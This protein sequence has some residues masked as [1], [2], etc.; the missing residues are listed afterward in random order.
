MTKLMRASDSLLEPPQD[1]AHLKLTKDAVVILEHFES[2]TEQEDRI[3][4]KAM[5]KALW[6]QQ[7]ARGILYQ[8]L[9]K[10]LN[11]LRLDITRSQGEHQ[12]ELKN[13]LHDILARQDRMR[14]HMTLASSA[15]RVYE[16]LL[17]PPPNSGSIRTP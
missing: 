12:L 15:R 3:Y 2:L 8:E 9:G 4:S 14:N 17:V 5:L 6:A 1:S 7:Q 11:P 13:K 16:K 10:L